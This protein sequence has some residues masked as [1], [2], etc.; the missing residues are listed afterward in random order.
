MGGAVNGDKYHNILFQNPGN[1]HS[2]VTLRL[3]GKKTNRAAIGARIKIETAG[4]TPQTIYRHVSSGS[5]FGANPLEQTIG[6]H[7]ATEIARITID[8][9]VSSTR[10][11]FE[12]V[13]I[14]RRYEIEEF[15]DALR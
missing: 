5:S 2:W 4:D 8:W 6:L 3:T 10:Q 1:Q 7:Q 11:V 13:A 14:N 12:N 9:P 15:D